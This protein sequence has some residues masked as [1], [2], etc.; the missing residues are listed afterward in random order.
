MSNDNVFFIKSKKAISLHSE[1]LSIIHYQL[2]PPI[3][4]TLKFT[5]LKKKLPKNFEKSFFFFSPLQIYK[6]IIR[7][8]ATPTLSILPFL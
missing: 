4:Q 1:K 5:F 7:N 6:N 8:E 2:N 3:P